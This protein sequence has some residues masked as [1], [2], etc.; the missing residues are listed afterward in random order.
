[1]PYASTESGSDG[2]ITCHNYY[3]NVES[4][5]T[6]TSFNGLWVP[7]RQV[8]PPVANSIVFASTNFPQNYSASKVFPLTSSVNWAPRMD[9]EMPQNVASWLGA[10]PPFSSLGSDLAGCYLV[11][12]DGDPSVHII[13]SELTAHTSATVT[14]PRNLMTTQTEIALITTA[15]AAAST[16]TL[17]RPKETLSAPSATTLTE[18]ASQTLGYG[19][20]IKSIAALQ[21]STSQVKSDDSLA[22]TSVSESNPSKSSNIGSVPSSHIPGEDPQ[23]SRLGQMIQSLISTSQPKP[24]SQRI[25]PVTTLIDDVIVGSSTMPLPPAKSGGPSGATLLVQIVPVGSSSI[26]LVPLVTGGVVLPGGETLKP[27]EATTIDDVPLSLP[28]S[29]TAIVM[30]STTTPLTL[31]EFQGAST[32]TP[33]VQTIDLGSQAVPAIVLSSEGTVLSGD[34]TLSAGQDATVNGVVVS[35]TPPANT[36]VIESTTIP[37]TVGSSVAPAPIVQTLTAGSQTITVSNLVSGG[38]VLAGSQTLMPGH[39]TTFNGIAMSLPPST[40]A[41]VVGGITIPLITGPRLSS[42]PGVGNYIFSALAQPPNS[43]PISA[44]TT[45]ITTFVLTRDAANPTFTA[46]S[47]LLVLT[48]S[49]QL[50]TL[51]YASSSEGV[52]LPKGQTLSYGAATT[53]NGIGLTLP[54]DSNATTFAKESTRSVS[55]P[56]VVTLGGNTGSTGA[57]TGR[58]TAAATTSSSAGGKKGSMKAWKGALSFFVMVGLALVK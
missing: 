44:S 7:G 28:V 45:A 24:A 42:R 27:G 38:L 49:S 37:L 54:V 8:L 43:V 46:S 33:T 22:R 10:L 47:P 19:G 5:A 39:L 15:P 58:S 48:V 23:S 2:S 30:G 17:D 36:I 56:G 21:Q 20:A 40:S 32:P 13:A 1:M 35:T 14:V 41:I 16:A 25:G 26:T 55:I 53:L 6:S 9:F 51:S 11:P 57:S 18:S 52:V 29:P 3:T 12:G 4:G 50:L 31:F 34:K